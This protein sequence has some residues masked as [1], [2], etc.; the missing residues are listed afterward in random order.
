MDRRAC[1][2][3]LLSEGSSPQTALTLEAKL[4]GLSI[5]KGL[6]EKLRKTCREQLKP[7]LRNH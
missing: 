1:E 5:I 2:E 3:D 6:L 7:Y 4:P